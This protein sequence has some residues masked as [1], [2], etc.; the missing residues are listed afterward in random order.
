MLKAGDLK[1]RV[2]F[3]AV[4]DVGGDYGDEKSFIP[5]L[6]CRCSFKQTA[7]KGRIVDGQEITENKYLV[8]LRKRTDVNESMQMVI[9][10][11][12]IEI[13]GI[14]QEKRETHIYGQSLK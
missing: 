12:T 7:T 14:L 10:G 3:N 2:Y 9:S 8:K 4:Q 6:N 13:T 5:A 1:Y 11:E